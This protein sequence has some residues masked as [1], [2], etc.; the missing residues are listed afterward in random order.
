LAVLSDAEVLLLRAS[1]NHQQPQFDE[2]YFVQRWEW[3]DV[4]SAWP[5]PGM[6][7]FAT[8]VVKTTVVKSIAATSTNYWM[9]DINEAP[10]GRSANVARGGSVALKD[11]AHMGYQYSMTDVGAVAL[12]A[13]GRAYVVVESTI[14]GKNY[15]FRRYAHNMTSYKDLQKFWVVPKDQNN[16]NVPP[17]G[18][19]ILGEPRGNSPAEVYVVMTNGTIYAFD[20]ESL[21]L[22][23]TRQL[24]RSNGQPLDI[25]PT[26]QPVLHGNRLW[27][28]STQGELRGIVVNSNGLSKTAQWPTMHRD[29]C[30]SNSHVSTAISL[31]SCF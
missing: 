21:T 31:P 16:L 23:W 20:A 18:S 12:D 14:D 22:R 25:A 9:T 5:S 27:L 26:A 6:H 8:T 19:P 10:G 24:L 1:V 28:V 7:G 17:V 11:D 30:N 13:G 3:D 29:N 4:D 2:D 15:E